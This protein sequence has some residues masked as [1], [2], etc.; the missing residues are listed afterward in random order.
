[1]NRNGGVAGIF[2]AVAMAWVGAAAPLAAQG[3][4]I[5]QVTL[6]NTLAANDDNSTDAVPLGIGGAN[7]INFFGQTFTQVY[8]NN[9]GNVTFGGP[10]SEFT[11]NAFSQGVP[12]GC[13]NVS[14]NCL[15]IIAPFFADVDTSGMGSGLVMYG[16]ATVQDEAGQSHNAFVANYVNVGYCCGETDKLNSFQLILIDRS[17]QGPGDFDIEY[18]Y[19]TIL[20][21]TG[22]ASG[23]TDGL[24]G[25]SAAV[26]YSNGQTGANNIYFQLPGS[27]VNGALINGG[28]DAL[29]SHSLNS[30]VPGRYIFP[31][32]QGQVTLFLSSLSCV[33]G[34]LGQGGTSTCTVG[35]PGSAPAGAVTNVTLSSS[36]PSLTVPALV[37][38]PAGQN[39]AT[40]T[41]TAGNVTSNQTATITGSFGG[42]SLTTTISL[43]NAVQTGY[44]GVF[45]N[46]TPPS[47][48][49]A[50]LTTLCTA[51]TNADNN[52]NAGDGGP[53]DAPVFTFVNTS[54]TDI[55]DAVITLIGASGQ[56]PGDSFIINM[57][58]IPANSF[59]NV[60]PGLSNDGQNHGA[61]NFFTYTGTPYDSS[62][63]FPSLNSTQFKFTGQQGST[64]IQSVDVCGIVA[65]PVFTPACTQGVSN[66]GTVPNIN[67]LGGPGDNDGPCDNCFGP[68]IV[69]LLNTVTSGGGPPAVTISTTSLS[70]GTV[71]T[72]GT[73]TFTATGGTGP[74]TWSLAG[75][76]LPPGVTLAANGTLSGTPTKPGTYTFSVKVTDANGNT[77]VE[78]VT[79][80]IATQP[81]T[82]TTPSPLPS[83]MVSVQ[84]PT[85]VLSATGGF[86]PYTFK[87]SDNQLPAGLTLSSNGTI[88]GTPTATGTSRLTIVA[89]DVTGQTGS[90]TLSITIRPLSPDLTTSSGSLSFTLA[91]GATALPPAQ[92]VYVEAT[93]TTTVVGW[94]ATNTPAVSW[95][96][97]TGGKSGSITPGSFSVSLTSAAEQLAAS[98]TPYTA[99]IVVA[100]AASSPCAGN[101]QNITVSLTVS[102]VS[103]ELSALTD[104]LSF[105]TAAANPQETTQAVGVEN[106]GGGTLSFTSVTCGETWCVPPGAAPG[107]LGGGATTN[108]N[109]QANPAGLSAGFY[110][111]ELTIVSS[112][113]TAQV[114][115]TLLIQSNPSLVLS[116]S[117]NQMTVPAGGV[118]ANP[119]TTFLVNITGAASANTSVAWT[120][121]LLPGTTWLNLSTTSGSST[122]ALP[123]TIS[124]S[125]NQSA[126]SALAAGVY[127]GTIRVTSA[128]AV[129]SPQDFQ[130]VLDVEAANAPQAP[131]PTPAGLIFVTTANGTAPPA[132]TDTVYAST[133]ASVPYQASATTS[134]GANWLSVSPATGTTS[135][136]QP[137]QTSI[138]VNPTGLAA[139]IYHGTVSYSLAAAAVP[140]VNVTLIVKGLP[141]GARPGQPIPLVTSCTPTKIV[142]TQTALVNDF[143]APASWP[144]PLQVQLNDDCGNAVVNGQVVSTFSNGD[145][146]LIL[147]PQDATSGL[148]SATWTPHGSSAQVT[149]LASASAT[150]LAPATELISGQVV[151]NQVPTINPGGTVHAFT[152]QTGQPLAPG[153]WMAIYGSDLADETLIN[154]AAVFPP[155]L[156]GTQVII[157]GEQAPLYFVS[158][159][160]INALI[161]YD[162]SAGQ[163]YQVIVSNNGALS[164]PASFTASAITPGV[165]AYASGYAEAEDAITGNLITAT[166][167]AKPGEYIAIYL[168]GMGPTST[169]VASGQPSPPNELTTTQPTV[170]LNGENITPI[171]Y[172]GLTPTA[173]GLYQIDFQVPADAPNGALPLVVTE[174]GIVAPSVILPVHN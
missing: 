107:S 1:M 154:N 2:C 68:Q 95:L 112:A 117:G 87:L 104:L 165:A 74:Y 49:P 19:N 85:Q 103:P 25:T 162:L 174:G 99:T 168:L 30:T 43:T 67:F 140:A 123:G 172:S 35:L 141:S 76:T 159:G 98:T 80:T 114:P 40:F 47:P 81:V 142:P 62:D 110:F 102:T 128:G 53:V 167:P 151:P 88:S 4:A 63:E 138:S 118:V 82:I 93:Q 92:T 125:L 148:Y 66:D 71:S 54:S 57:G 70:N 7:G 28:P 52:P 50:N 143:A 77:A 8:V 29:I 144:T 149:V 21:E 38:V 173:V 42:N 18:N 166:S 127:Y 36:S 158:T 135:A 5:V 115:V 126:V 61:N 137:A 48:C 97:V 6:P 16:N 163:T 22:D 100:C 160:Q 3:N 96:T 122:S 10:F 106:S 101:S 13:D 150:G 139:G 73:Q 11:P 133:A 31:V 91:A 75:G 58:T 65:P 130:V 41:A 147:V 9:N 27:L 64:Q 33:P 136:Q 15:P 111:T 34:V 129:N 124:Y 20:W 39:T 145:P 17:D 46:S 108:I 23:G 119:D 55:T 12:E 84:Y 155:T 59:K 171:L 90:A 94:S 152:P 170:T 131:N 89:T 78:T 113:G 146:P 26:G 72:A 79:F 37:T 156:A 60:I 32:R 164:P 44:I 56:Y 14:E 134:D 116:P 51:N 169:P 153:T 24:G 121:S 157:G 45:Y 120:A 83:G 109:V 86:A 69:A 161:P 132:Q 105:N